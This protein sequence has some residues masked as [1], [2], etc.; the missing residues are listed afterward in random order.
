MLDGQMRIRRSNPGAQRVLHLLPSDTGRSINDL[1]MTLQLDNLDR[2]ITDVVDNLE[3]KEMEVQDKEG[4][5]YI[6]RVRPYRTVDNKI[7]GAVL[8]L[9]DVDQFKR[10]RFP[11]AS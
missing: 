8:V 11:S 6:L 3:S 4:R 1:K 7:E 10:P 2:I 5:W 9:I